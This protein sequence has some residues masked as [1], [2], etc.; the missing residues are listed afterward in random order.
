MY[1]HVHTIMRSSIYLEKGRS[2]HR[3]VMTISTKREGWSYS[4]KVASWTCVTIIVHIWGAHERPTRIYDWNH[5]N[6]RFQRIYI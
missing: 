3:E 2:I 5:T 1:V 4:G 6:G